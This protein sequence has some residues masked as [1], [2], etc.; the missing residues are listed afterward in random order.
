M[1]IGRE[2]ETGGKKIDVRRRGKVADEERDRKRWAV[3][4]VETENS[5]MTKE[6]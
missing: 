1:K 2:R 5:E 6:L 4:E 3:R